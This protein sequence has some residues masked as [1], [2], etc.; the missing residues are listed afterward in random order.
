MSDF[1]AK[2]DVYRTMMTPAS[3]HRFVPPPHPIHSG[4]VAEC[5]S[6]IMTKHDGYPETYRMTVPL[7]AGF[8]ETVFHYREI[9]AISGRHDFPK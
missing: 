1:N 8:G 2:A 3:G 4:T 9:E 5:I 7:E 6:W